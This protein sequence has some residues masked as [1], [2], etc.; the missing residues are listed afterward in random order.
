MLRDLALCRDAGEISRADMAVEGRSGLRRLGLHGFVWQVL[1]WLWGCGV[2]G[3]MADTCPGGECAISLGMARVLACWRRVLA[4]LSWL[5]LLGPAW[6]WWP[7]S[8]V[9]SLLW[10]RVSG[11]LAFLAGSPY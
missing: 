10:G 7:R 4:S 2:V 9:A 3:L 1:C 6:R 5:A 11:L 8:L